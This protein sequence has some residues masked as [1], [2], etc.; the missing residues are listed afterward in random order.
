MGFPGAH[1]Q[2]YYNEEGEPIGYDYP[3]YDPPEEYTYSDAE[4]H[5]DRMFDALR[6]L[7]IERE[8]E[9]TDELFVWWRARQDI[10]TAEDAYWAWKEQKDGPV[11]RPSEACG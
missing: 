3:E 2:I 4:D 6:D 8:G 7:M 10:E 1:A 11:R 9:D 5:Q